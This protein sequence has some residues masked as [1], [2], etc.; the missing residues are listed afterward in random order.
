MYDLVLFVEDQLRDKI[1]RLRVDADRRVDA[2]IEWYVAHYG[3]PRRYFDLKPIK[4]RLLRAADRREL[5][6]HKT[7]RDAGIAEGELL[8]LVSRKGNVVWRTAEALLDEIEQEV[9][10]LLVEEVWDRATQKLAKIEATQTCGHRVQQ[11]RRWVDEVGGPAKLL[12]TAEKLAEALALY[13]AASTW[14]KH[15]LTVVT[16]MGSSILFVGALLLGNATVPPDNGPTATQP[17]EPATVTATPTQT[18]TPT[19]TPTATATPTP[20]P[21]STPTVTPKH[22]PTSTPTPTVTLTRTPPCVR[23]QPYGWVSYVV[24]RGNTLYSLARRTGTTVAQIQRVNCLPDTRIR[25]GEWLW[26]PPIPEPEPPTRPPPPADLIVGE[27]SGPQ[28]SCSKAA[29]GCVTRVSFSIMNAGAGN[30][31]GFN[32]RI[33]ADPSQ[34]VVINQP[35]TGLAPGERQRFAITTPPGG[36]C[37]DPDCT[38]CVTVD[39]DNDVIESNEQNNDLC[40][41]SIG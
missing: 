22:T 15:A 2:L 10:D 7:L 9:K 36:N 25:T 37:Y 6:R 41:T 12:N 13:R 11:V 26:L 20:T 17:P 23:K 18:A 35:A 27:L 1:V 30:A 21:T 38:V 39:S 4:Y 40:A 32:I 3:L 31:G 29:G 14:A 8:Q 19:A 33:A 5:H 24:Q 28:V 16:I 34:S